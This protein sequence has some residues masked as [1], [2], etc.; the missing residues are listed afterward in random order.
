VL[1]LLLE[2]LFKFDETS[3]KFLLFYA[4]EFNDASLNKW[5][6]VMFFPTK[7]DNLVAEKQD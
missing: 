5:Q 4:S 7:D 2:D 1:T 6:K 3:I